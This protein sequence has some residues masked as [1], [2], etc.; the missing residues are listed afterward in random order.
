MF[1]SGKICVL[2]IFGKKKTTG[3]V[4]GMSLLCTLAAIS[5]K[6]QLLPL[7]TGC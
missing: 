5:Q 2:G 1:I 6:E 3:K 7:M 4:G